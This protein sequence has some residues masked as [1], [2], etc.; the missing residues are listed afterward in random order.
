MDWN[1]Y[2]STRHIVFPGVNRTANADYSGQ[3]YSAFAST[4]YHL[5]A[6]KFTVTPFASLQYT[7]MNLNSYTETGAGDIDLRVNSQNYNFLESGLGV[8]VE[9]DFSYNGGVYAPEVHAKWL[10]ELNNP[11]AKNTAAFTVAGA[12][13]FTTQGLKPSDDTLDLGVG[14]TLLSCSCSK[15]TWS[16]EAVYDHDWR[17][18]GYSANQAMIRLSDSF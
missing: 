13:S 12:P 5:P 9:R 6:Q 3:D 11:T 10:H 1:N 14:I 2:S 7:H 4:G 15:K 17:N 18:D 8:K 16:V